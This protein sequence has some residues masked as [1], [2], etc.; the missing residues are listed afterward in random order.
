MKPLDTWDMAV[1]ICAAP[2]RY[3]GPRCVSTVRDGQTMGAP[4]W[5]RGRGA[6]DASGLV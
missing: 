3:V 1:W 4:T 2:V 6:C 5:T